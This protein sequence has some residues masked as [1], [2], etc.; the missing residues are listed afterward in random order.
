MTSDANAITAKVDAERRLEDG[1]GLS[2]DTL[3]I[4]VT[5]PQLGWVPNFYYQ[6]IGY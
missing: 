6:V 3:T 1:D 2:K 5:T 4:S